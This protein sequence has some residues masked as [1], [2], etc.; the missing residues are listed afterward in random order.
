MKSIQSKGRNS[1][2]LILPLTAALMA[3]GATFKAYGA[4]AAGTQI[5]NLATVSYEDSSGNSF[6]AQSNEAVVTVAQ[7]Y[8]ATITS[9]DTA[10]D[11]SPGQ[12]VDISYTLENTGNGVDTYVLAAIDGI[13]G[14]DAVD[15]DN[16]TVFED[17]NNN[18]QADTGE[19]VISDLTLNAGEI[20]SIVVRAEVPTSAVDGDDLGITLTVEAEQG[21]GAAV[22]ESVTDLTAGKGPDTLDG[23]VESLITV[24]GD[25]VV[26]PT[27]ESVHNPATN[28][29]TYTI[30]VR[31]NGNADATS[32]LIRDA[33][34]EN[35]T[36]V[37]GSATTS[38][39]ID[40]NGDT[41]PVAIVLDEIADGIDYNGDGTLDA[42]VD[43][44]GAT[45][46]V[47]PANATVTITYT[48]SYDPATVPGGTVITNTAYVIADLDGDGTAEPEISTNEVPDT[49]GNNVLVSITDTIENT[50]GDGIN[51][52]QDDDGDNDIQLVDQVAAGDEVI[53]KN[54]VTN[55]SNISDILELSVTSSTFPTGTVFTFE[56]EDATVQL[57]DS[58]GAFG[59]DAG[60]I[61][62]GASETITVIAQ[63]PA[64]VNGPGD[65]DA[66]IT[67]SSASD[68][69]VTD[70]VTERL[71]L[72]SASTVDIHNALG[73]T[74]DTDDDPL[75]APDYS[76]VNTT[77]TDVNTTVNIRLYIDNDGDAGNSFQL[78][79]GGSYDA[80]NQTLG[81]LPTGWTVEFFLSDGSGAPVGNPITTTPNI[82]GQTTDVEIIAVV[83]IPSDQ[84]QAVGDFVFDN[85]AD[86]TVETLD[87]NGDGDGD[88]PLFF[89]I[90]SANTGASDV[91]LEAIDVNAVVAASL[92]P[93]GAAQID[94]GGTEVYQNTLINNGNATETYEVTSA[95][96][97]P[98]WTNT[99][100]VDTDGDGVADRVLGNLVP[101]DIQV[102]QP[103]GTV[104]TV[105]VT[106]GAGGAPE[107]TLD[108]GEAL[109]ITTTVF[110]P[111]TAP[112][113]QVDVLTITATN[114]AT[115]DVVSAQ[116]QSQAVT[117][118]VRI[119][120]EAAVDNDCDGV[121][122]TPF[123]A[124]QPS[125]VEPDQC[126]IWR[127]VAE[128]QGAA[129]A[130]NVQVRDAAPAFTTFVPGS[131]GYCLNLGCTVAP[132]TDGADGDAGEESA[133]DVVFYIGNGSTPG[134]GLGGELVSG[135]QATVQFSVRVD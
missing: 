69:T 78:L 100:S 94:A 49:I 87:G 32:V 4:T 89:Q 81:S 95:N 17:I 112:E 79:S 31:N 5:K 124:I 129:D 91:T 93:N 128:N 22:A 114:T 48:V 64:S 50:G 98:G 43:G 37:P 36:L 125:T 130:F 7:V 103:D 30:T 23:T 99:M 82:P 60:V 74:I 104:T 14:G 19:P 54:I 3:A 39:L 20:R 126:V 41:L 116:N 21:T 1:A 28:E 46:V 101:G 33:I 2:W 70:T 118:T 123:A 75:G 24:T 96:S 83:T 117:G 34:P 10:V 11:A 86:G 65:Y 115:G 120:K 8:S 42:A 16:I 134:A 131:M 105:E 55:N 13:A 119:H 63:L 106:T 92:T 67:V 110:A 102:Q 72:I 45:D 109:P 59:V 97:Q 133:G 113:N 122:D 108:A 58:N 76:A 27:L 61:A 107:F 68:S 77:D 85:D 18:G 135:D 44:L 56:N 90:S 84:T 111:A 9:T 53:F 12:P 6:T 15:A 121:A 52:G 127:V 88:F 25:A 132:V 26:G 80:T 66:V 47:L 29:I 35:T 51:D 40:A 57:S 71:S 73:G 38:G 62:P